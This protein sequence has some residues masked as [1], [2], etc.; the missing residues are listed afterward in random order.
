MEA[1]KISNSQSNP[2]PREQTGSII[3]IYD[4]KRHCRTHTFHC[5]MYKVMLYET[6]GSMEKNRDPRSKHTFL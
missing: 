3:I 5:N 4:F 1:Q 6:N 2:G